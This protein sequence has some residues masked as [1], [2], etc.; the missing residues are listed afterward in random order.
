MGEQEGEVGS[1]GVHN[2]AQQESVARYAVI[3]SHFGRQP[4]RIKGLPQSTA[5]AILCLGALLEKSK[6]AYNLAPGWL[7]KKNQN[8][9]GP[10]RPKWLYL[11]FCFA[12]AL[13][14][15]DSTT[16]L[17]LKRTTRSLDWVFLNTL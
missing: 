10:S 3:T 4:E 15:Y 14:E 6:P 17:L 5:Q 9:T 2:A 16:P 13:Y 12:V 8:K 1:L 11:F 7:Y